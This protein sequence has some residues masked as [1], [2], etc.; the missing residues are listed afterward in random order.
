MNIANGEPGEAVQVY[1]DAGDQIAG[2]GAVAVEGNR[3][4]IGSAPDKKLLDCAAK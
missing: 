4:L 3:L 2:A 1:G